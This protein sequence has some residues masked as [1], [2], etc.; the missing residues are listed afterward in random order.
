MLT[1]VVASTIHPPPYDFHC[2]QVWM[3]HESYAML[4]P[5]QCMSNFGA[6]SAT[7]EGVWLMMG[8]LYQRAFC[9]V[10]TQWFESNQYFQSIELRVKKQAVWKK[11]VI[12][13]T[14]TYW[15]SISIIKF[16]FTQLH[17][18]IF[19][20]YHLL[21]PDEHALTKTNDPVSNDN[22]N[23]LW[24][25]AAF[26]WLTSPKLSINVDDFAPVNQN[27]F[28]ISPNW[29]FIYRGHKFEGGY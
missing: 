21:E 14:K 7:S 11:N 29:Y 2:Q 13:T 15:F 17:W 24:F 1:I 18:L 10:T 6:K 8:Q 3:D 20:I 5:V 28:F 26:I 12:D 25:Q 27:P 16:W 22:S 4:H 23:L 19:L 9:H